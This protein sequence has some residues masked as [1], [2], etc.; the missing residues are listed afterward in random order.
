MAYAVDNAQQLNDFLAGQFGAGAQITNEINTYF[1]DLGRFPVSVDTAQGT[2]ANLEILSPSDVTT[3]AGAPLEFMAEVNQTLSVADID[4]SGTGS[5]G[6]MLTDANGVDFS[7]TGSGNDTIFG[8]DGIDTIDA[9]GA[10]DGVSASTGNN[11]YYTGNND[12][13]VH[14]GNG[15]ETFNI[16]F[17]P[18]LDTGTTNT[19]AITGGAGTNVAN[20]NDHLS[21]ANVST[22]SGVTTVDFISGPNS[23]QDVTLTNVQNVNFS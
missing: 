13:T 6:V 17:I 2:G 10:T 23:G 14:G 9:S 1:T 21:D 5:I 16:N 15:N 19:I 11:T 12:E 18:G 8:G 3:T 22:T 20:F 7:L 4:V